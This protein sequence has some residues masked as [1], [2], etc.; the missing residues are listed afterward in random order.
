MGGFLYIGVGG[1]SLFCVDDGDG[2]DL[3]LR[4]G[5]FFTAVGVENYYAFASLECGVAAHKTDERVTR[6]SHVALGELPKL[7]PG[8]D[9]VVS[10][11]NYQL[12][13]L[14]LGLF[15]SFL[16][17][18][19]ILRGVFATLGNLSRLDLAVGRLEYT[20]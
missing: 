7:V 8:E 15:S 4:T 5:V 14:R 9:Q 20:H 10:V 3:L 2:A 13:L 1:L 17:A 6:E 12:G 11:Y 18:C 16:L 19:V